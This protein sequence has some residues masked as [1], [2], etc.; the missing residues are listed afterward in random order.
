MPGFTGI[1]F[2][3][4]QLMRKC[5]V[6]KMALISGAWKEADKQKARS[7]GC[8]VFEKPI[9]IDSLTN[10]FKKCESDINVEGRI[11]ASWFLEGASE[12]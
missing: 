11:L 6:R 12:A 4:N 8:K 3:A 1:E 9:D 2:L 5:K 7:L 10:W